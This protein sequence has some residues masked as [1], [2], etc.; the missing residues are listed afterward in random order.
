[1][2][3]LSSFMV[4]NI[5]GGDRVTYTYDEINDSTGEPISRNNKGNFYVVDDELREHIDAIRDFIKDN[6]LND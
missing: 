5:G 3:Q 1:M 6:K 2:K 4:L